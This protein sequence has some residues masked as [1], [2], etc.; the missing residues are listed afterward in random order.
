MFNNHRAGR[1][2][3]R[4]EVRLAELANR[5]MP[6]HPYT[7]D[8]IQAM[9]EEIRGKVAVIVTL[10]SRRTEWCV[11]ALRACARARACMYV[12]TRSNCATALH[13]LHQAQ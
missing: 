8:E 5:V 3:A 1:T 12:L 10:S 13:R 9:K 6:F 4:V 2:Q 7:D 11:R